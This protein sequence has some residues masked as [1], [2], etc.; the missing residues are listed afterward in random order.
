[1][2]IAH[3]FWK[4]WLPQ[5]IKFRYQTPLLISDYTLIPYSSILR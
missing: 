4:G 3:S 2:K 5:I 1:M